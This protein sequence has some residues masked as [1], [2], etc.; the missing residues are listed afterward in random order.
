MTSWQ[1]DGGKV[2]KVTDFIFLDSKITVDGDCNHEI[3]RHLLLERKAMMNLDSILKSRVDDKGH[4]SQSYVFSCSHVWKWELDHKE[5]WV[6]IYLLFSHSV[7]SSCLWLHGLQHV[8]LP[9]LS[10]LPRAHSNSCPLSWWCYPIIS[11]TVIPCSL[12][13]QSF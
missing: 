2:E 7:M 6:R 13:L 4:Y 9:C 1:V 12:L 3:K 8:W 5:G 10:P 11:S